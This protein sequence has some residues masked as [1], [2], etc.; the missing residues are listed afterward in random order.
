[1]NLLLLLLLP[2][3][4]PP[5]LWD[6]VSVVDASVAQRKDDGDGAVGVVTSFACRIRDVDGGERGAVVCG[7]IDCRLID[8]TTSEEELFMNDGGQWKEFMNVDDD[9]DEDAAVDGVM[10]G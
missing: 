3:P 4:P 9:D 1:M 6:I 7:G 2:L 8:P 10:V 5:L